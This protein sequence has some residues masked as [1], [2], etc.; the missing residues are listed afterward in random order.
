[1]RSAALLGQQALLLGSQD[2]QRLERRVGVGL[3]FMIG[4]VTSF[5]QELFTAKFWKKHFWDTIIA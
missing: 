5:G 2:V 1:M 3:G 4:F